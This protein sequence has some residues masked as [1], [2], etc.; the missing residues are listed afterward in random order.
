MYGL[1]SALL[2]LGTLSL[3][4]PVP[5]PAASVNTCAAVSKVV[6][7]LKAQSTAAA[8]CTS[9]LKIT[10]STITSSRTITSTIPASATVT[11]GT[12]TVTASP[13]T[14]ATTIVVSA[15]STSTSTVFQPTTTT[16]T[17]TVISSPMV[18][19]TLY[20]CTNPGSPNAKRAAAVS[21]TTSSKANPLASFA[22]SALSSACRCLSLPTPATTVYVTGTA[23]VTST[24]TFQ[25]AATATYTPT[26]VQTVTQT[27][28]VVVQGYDYESTNLNPPDQIINSETATSTLPAATATA[29][30]GYCTSQG[31]YGNIH[32]Q[33]NVYLSGTS[34]S[35]S[36]PF[37]SDY[38]LTNGVLR[39]QGNG[40]YLYVLDGVNGGAVLEGGSV[41]AG[42]WA[43]HCTI[44]GNPGS[45]HDFACFNTQGVRYQVY[46]LDGSSNIQVGLA[47]PAG[48]SGQGLTWF[49]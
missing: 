36:F 5:A 23:S 44:A 34:L 48:A 1:V 4:N 40:Q 47:V 38:S 22:S 17:S 31:T 32:N 3:A 30:P 2:A 11:T 6:S 43:L 28:T 39:E 8:F 18:T 19:V 7:A 20:D 16:T 25:T 24:T 9:F 27:T 45:M 14:T 46:T 21:T 37:V 33:N 13:V 12:N 35:A 10:T 29:T 26:V 42:A 41:P 15:S 49:G